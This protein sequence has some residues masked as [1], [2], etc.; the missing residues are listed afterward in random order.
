[1]NE[2]LA[3][4]TPQNV[5]LVGGFAESVYLQDELTRSLELRKIKMRKPDRYKA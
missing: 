5:F 2:Q 4:F 1:M 3:N